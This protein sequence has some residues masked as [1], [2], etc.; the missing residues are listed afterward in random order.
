MTLKDQLEAVFDADRAAREAE[1]KLMATA[2][3][4]TLVDALAE[5][6]EEALA[7]T[8]RRE[9][10]M[11]LERLA[12]ACAQVPGPRM[13]DT[14]IAILNDEEPIVRVAAGEA[15]L[16]VGYDR[17]AEVARAVERAAD[18]GLRGPAMEE[19]P[20]ILVEIGEPS[21]L[22]LV[23]RFLTHPEPEAVAAGIE[24]LAAL[25]DPDAIPALSKLVADSRT[26]SLDDQE[27]DT[28]ATLGELASAVIEELGRA[29][30]D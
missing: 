29:P 30:A 19:L 6:T 15:L 21:A 4:A 2:D 20:W 12:D 18:A 11:R 26:V 22:K 27:G 7:L 13:T 3:T 23:Q 24:A 5:A 25:G 17:Y 9:A 10:T 8:D 14:L 1:R 16:D 28:M